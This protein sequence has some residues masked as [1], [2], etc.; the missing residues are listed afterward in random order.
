MSYVMYVVCMYM[1]VCVY[2]HTH[3]FPGTGTVRCVPRYSHALSN[4]LKCHELV[5]NLHH[6]NPTPT[7]EANFL[8]ASNEPLPC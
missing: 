3:L 5:M 1:Y 7:F 4:K 6:F 2:T 8:G